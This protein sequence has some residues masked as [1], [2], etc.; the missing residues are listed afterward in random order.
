VLSPKTNVDLWI[1]PLFGD[2]KPAPFIQTEFIETQGRFS[3]D[4]HWVAYASNESGPYQV[5]VQSFPTSGGKWQVSTGGGAQ[6]QWRH[7]GKELFYLAPDRKLMTVEINSTG[8][9]FVPGVPKPFSRRVSV[10]SSRP[11]G[12]TYYAVASNGQRFL[13]N[14]LAGEPAL[15]LTVVLNW[16][17]GLKR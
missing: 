9:T 13:V 1:L 4:G 7:D 5:Y 12:G 6:P 14:T 15:P 11:S 3:P 17:A 2:Q 10:L 8:P 16:T